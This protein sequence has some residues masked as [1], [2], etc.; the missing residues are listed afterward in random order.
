MAKLAICNGEPLRKKPFPT[1]PVFD[2][3][4]QSAISQVLESGKWGHTHSPESRTVAFETA[5]AEFHGVSYAVSL[6]SGSTALEIPL[7]ICIRVCPG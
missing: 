4:E 7:K 5:F 1:W 3:R 2:D 6:T